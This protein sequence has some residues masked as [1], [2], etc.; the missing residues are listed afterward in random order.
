ML[1]DQVISAVSRKRNNIVAI[2]DLRPTIVVYMSKEFYMKSKLELGT[3]LTEPQWLF[4]NE[5][6][7][8][9][10]DVYVVP[11]TIVNNRIHSHRNFKVV[12]EI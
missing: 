7:V 8:L 2:S 1:I 5:S 10:Y 9:G 4:R 11:D 12:S 6:T 3:S